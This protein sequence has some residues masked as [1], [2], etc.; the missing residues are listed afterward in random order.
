MVKTPVVHTKAGI[1]ATIECVVLSH[2]KAQIHWFFNEKPLLK[3]YNIMMKENDMVSESP[4][5]INN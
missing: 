5:I 3:N 4:T 1:K 2:P